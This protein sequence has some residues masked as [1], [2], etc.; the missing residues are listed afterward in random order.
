[1]GQELAQVDSVE[2]ALGVA[3][4]LAAEAGQWG[5]VETLSRELG[6]RRR[7]RTAP[8]VASLEAERAKRDRKR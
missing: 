1:V 7:A 2:E 3:L 4:K 6:E 5:A 8:A